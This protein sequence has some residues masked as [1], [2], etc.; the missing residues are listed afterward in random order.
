MMLLNVNLWV[1]KSAFIFA[2]ESVFSQIN[3]YILSWN[4]PRKYAPK[5]LETVYKYLQSKKKLLSW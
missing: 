2:P 5:T 1:E 4:K 3:Y